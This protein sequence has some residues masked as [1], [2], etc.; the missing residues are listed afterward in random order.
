MHSSLNLTGAPSNA[1][2][3]EEIVIHD[4]TISDGAIHDNSGP[5]AMVSEQHHMIEMHPAEPHHMI[6]MPPSIEEEP[7]HMI[8]MN[9]AEAEPHHMM[10][11]HP[12]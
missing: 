6:E 11:M 7:H 2:P 12:A 5:I 1:S 8:D 3:A 4:S 9:P 10:E